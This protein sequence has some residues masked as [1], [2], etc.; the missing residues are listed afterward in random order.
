LRELALHLLDIAENSVS[1]GARNIHIEVDEDLINDQLHM[2]VSDDGRGMDPETVAKVIDPFVT[3]RTTRKVGLGIPLL[4]A[5]AEACSGYLT[6]ESEL[7]KGT[8]VRVRFQHSHIDRMPL[9][10]IAGTFLTLLIGS[11]EVHWIFTYRV[12]GSEF[13]FDDDEMKETLD[14]VSMTE[15]SVLKFI[16]EFIVENINEVRAMA[17]SETK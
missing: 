13:I 10:D 17:L 3:S 9:G 5:A 12:N 8:L 1:A 14:G 4:K 2:S 7:G 11:P 16:R 15:P 6:I